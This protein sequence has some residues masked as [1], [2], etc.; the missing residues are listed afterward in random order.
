MYEHI[1][2]HTYLHTYIHI[3][4]RS[5]PAR[6]A[7]LS[8]LLE[9]LSR[10]RTVH[11]APTHEP[12]VLQMRPTSFS[13]GATLCDSPTA[14]I[15]SRSPH[16]SPWPLLFPLTTA[17][18]HR[19]RRRFDHLLLTV[20]AAYERPPSSRLTGLAPRRLDTHPLPITLKYYISFSISR[21]YFL[22]R[23]DIV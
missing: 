10:G 19:R 15:Y 16:P 1:K 17:I 21:I 13:T 6:I 3:G 9:G 7:V 5:S 18:L 2:I 20:R 22:R 4:A 14:P 11:H 12:A 23:R 8:R